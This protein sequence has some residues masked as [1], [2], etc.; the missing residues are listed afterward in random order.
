MS[1]FK[2]LFGSPSSNVKSRPD[3]I[4]LSRPA[5]FNGI[6]SDLEKRS[7]SDCIA[8]LLI[9]HFQETHEK[10]LSIAEEYQGDVPVMAVLAHELSEEIATGLAV[11][12]NKTIELIIAERHPL[13]KHD[14]K[15]IEEFAKSLACRCRSTCHVAMDDKLMKVFAGES[16]IQL[17]QQMGMKEEDR[18]ES[19]MVSRRIR[20]AQKQLESKA[21][22]NK[23]TKSEDEW[24]ETNLRDR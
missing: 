23:T 24:F 1:F 9:S 12:E 8:V 13:P 7:A 11:D 3:S 22:G 16:M 15:V 19:G 18:I 4:W 2:A 14:D 20:A 10:M 17:L 5:K 21:I 6:R